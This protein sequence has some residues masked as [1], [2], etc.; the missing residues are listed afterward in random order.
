MTHELT[1]APTATATALDFGESAGEGGALATVGPGRLDLHPAAVYLAGLTPGSRETMRRA[2]TI[3]ARIVTAD[4]SAD[5]MALPWERMRFQHTN[6]VRSQLAA[7]YAPSTAN[8][9]LSAVRGVLRAAWRL[10]LMTAEEYQRAADLTPVRGERVAAGRSVPSGE[11]A[12]LLNTCGQDAGGIRDAA[13]IGV[14][15][16]CGL[17]RAELVG[18]DLAH[19]EES[20]DGARLLVRGK[21]NKERVVPLVEGA[22]RALA[23]WLTVRGGAPGPLFHVLGNRNRG[24]RMTTQ[25][26]YSMLKTRA[27]AAGVPALSPHDLR[28]T[29]VGDLLDAGADIAIV[30]KL[31]GHAN[32]ATTSR[33]DRRPEAVKRAAVNKLHVPYSRRVLNNR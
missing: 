17:R 24:G 7:R 27:A 20:A 32:P 11:L 9:I 31:A 5:C 25:A 29:F 1:P 2:L 3:V 21:G 26:V 22:A 19:L 15:Y 18:L 4:E 10:R 33:Y 14:L 8:L 16:A 28:R 23:D 13:I 12:A 6:A 30:Q